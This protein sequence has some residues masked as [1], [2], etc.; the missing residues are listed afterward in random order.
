MFNGGFM[1]RIVSVSYI[2][3]M[4]FMVAIYINHSNPN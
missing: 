3:Y 4:D 2:R 1:L